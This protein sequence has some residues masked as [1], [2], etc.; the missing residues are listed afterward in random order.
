MLGRHRGG[1]RQ[2]EP[3]TEAGA[4]D[5]PGRTRLDR[6]VA[7]RVARRVVGQEGG[8]RRGEHRVREERARTR[9]VRVRRVENHALG[10]T[11]R[12][13]RGAHVGQ[14]RPLA[15]GD[16]ENPG[17]LGVPDRRRERADAQ[18]QRHLEHD[19]AWCRRP[20]RA[21]VSGVELHRAL[22]QRG[23]IPERELSERER[24]HPPARPV[25]RPHRRD[26]LRDVL[27]VG[28]HVLHRGRTRRPGDAGQCLDPVQPRTDGVRDDVVPRGPGR[29][30][31]G[32]ARARR[33]VRGRHAGAQVAD[34]D[35]VE[36]RVGHE[37]VR[38]ATEHEQ[39][40]ARVIGRP[41]RLDEVGLARRL[42]IA[43][44]RPADLQGRELREGRGPGRGRHCARLART[45]AA[46]RI[47]PRPMTT[48][49]AIASRACR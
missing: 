11:Q 28:A 14:R 44:R 43:A 40:L 12:E 41:D 49:I 34:D 15:D 38:A 18:L 42:H 32:H 36:A 48:G 46:A 22:E 16:V 30:H 27:A 1:S 25:P 17:Q 35:T 2:A 24:P 8:V 47:T 37:D 9:G 13:H 21:R 10:R 26:R 5:E 20:R 23:A 7:R 6:V 29:H 19:V 3:A 45:G 4:L 39:R 31:D 33:V